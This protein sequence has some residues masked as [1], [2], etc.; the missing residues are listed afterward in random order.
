VTGRARRRAMRLATAISVSVFALAHATGGAA[1]GRSGPVAIPSAL[2]CP[3]TA[4]ASGFSPYCAELVPV[5]ELRATHGTLELIPRPSPF[6]IAVTVDGRQRYGLVAHIDGLPEPRTLGPYTVYIAWAAT[7]GLDS[8]V[9]LGPVRNGQ[10]ALGELARDQFRV[11]VSAERSAAVTRRTGKLVLRATSPS[12]RLLAH[13]D[14]TLSVGPG[15]A[16]AAESHAHAA[17]SGWRMPPMPAGAPAIAMPMMGVMAPSVTPFRAAVGR[18]LAELPV[19]GPRELLRVSDGD[20]ITLEA[21]VVRRTIAGRT[22]AMYGFNGQVPGPLIEATQGTTITVRFVNAIDQPSAVHWHGVRLDNSSDGVPGVTQPEIAPGG[23]F[24]YRVHF[25]D[26]GIYWYH[27]HHREDIQQD[28]GLYG[29]LLV[30]PNGESF[31]PAN[32]EEVLALDDLLLDADGP[33]PYGREAPTYALMGRF[34]NVMLVNGEPRYALSVTR[35]E[36]VR[37]YLT[38]VASARLFNLSFAGARVKLIASD[39]G[40]FERETWVESVPIAPAERY[41]VDVQFMEPGVHVLL[42]R[43]QALDH[44]RGTFAPETDTLGTVTVGRDLAAPR[45]DT[46]FAK[47]RQNAEVMREMRT[48]LRFMDTPPDRSLVIGL[49]TTALPASVAVMLNGLSIPVDWNDGMPMMN[50][51]TTDREITWTL[52]DPVTGRTNMDIGWTFGAGDLVKLRIYNDPSAKH[53]MDHPDP[54]SRST[55]SRLAPRWYGKRESRVE[56]HRHHSGR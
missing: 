54:S 29:N 33:S 16:P 48:Y 55:L 21:R 13:R 27:P 8:M 22:F 53:A 2:A 23:S 11:L 24:L 40:R 46:T 42:N 38:N 41:V 30:R 45:Y 50:W 43:V 6:G 34:G 20:T 12:M 3:D 28:L 10:T 52:R 17:D 51:L 36:V 37:F 7:V 49:E 14:L 18:P 5:P 15:A 9:R 56:R 35:G 26:A 4:G 31:G 44:I 25:R 1:Q 19:A 47:L 32:R 39:G